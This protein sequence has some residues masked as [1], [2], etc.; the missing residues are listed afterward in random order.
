[1]SRLKFDTPV[2]RNVRGEQ[3]L[4]YRERDRGVNASRLKFDTPVKTE[5]SR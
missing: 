3:V 4:F 1:M 2:R 5:R